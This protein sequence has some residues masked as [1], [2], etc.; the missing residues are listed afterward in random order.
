MIF[1]LKIVVAMLMVIAIGVGTYFG[2]LIG[3]LLTVGIAIV[4]NG[5]FNRWDAR[6]QAAS[7][8]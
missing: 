3:F 5:M 4:L 6:R 2:N 8:R 1:L 7:T